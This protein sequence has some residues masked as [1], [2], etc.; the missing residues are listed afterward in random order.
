MGRNVT[1]NLDD[2]LLKAARLYALEADT[3]LTDIVRDH[4]QSLTWT[5]AKKRSWNARFRA[6]RTE[7]GMSFPGGFVSKEELHGK[8]PRPDGHEHPALRGNR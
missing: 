4:L 1:F 5:D 3:T 2:D 7:S 6:L 8:A